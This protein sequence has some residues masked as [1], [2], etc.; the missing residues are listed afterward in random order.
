MKSVGRTSLNPAGKHVPGTMKF[1]DT[2]IASLGPEPAQ[3][4]KA[5]RAGM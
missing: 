4:V 2:L 5:L 3:T 1:A